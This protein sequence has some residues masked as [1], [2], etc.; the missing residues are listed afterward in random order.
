MLIVDNCVGSFGNQVPNG[1]PIL[2]FEGDKNDRELIHLSSYLKQVLKSP[3]PV[4]TNRQVFKI[5]SIRFCKTPQQY[6]EA[7]HPS[8]FSIKS[9]LL[10]DTSKKSN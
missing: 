7:L 9:D 1:I 10:E 8:P 5:D 4:E 3:T 6:L 2:P